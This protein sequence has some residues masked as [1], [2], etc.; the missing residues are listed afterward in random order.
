MSSVLFSNTQYELKLYETI[1]PVLFQQKK[2]KVYADNKS[3]EVLLNSRL[4]SVTSHCKQAELLLGKNFTNLD[5]QCMEK[6]LFATDYKS[7]KNFENSFG[8]FYWRKGR[9]QI[10]FNL[11]LIQKFKLYLPQNMKKYAQ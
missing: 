1:L 6:P 3:K 4:F 9:P 2:L 5:R 10:K 7:F 11:K 8:A